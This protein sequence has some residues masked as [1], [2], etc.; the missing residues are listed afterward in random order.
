MHG[1]KSRNDA[2]YWGN[3]EHPDLKREDTRRKMFKVFTYLK[4]KNSRREI[5]FTQ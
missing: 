2:E 1:E 4:G 5:R 3:W